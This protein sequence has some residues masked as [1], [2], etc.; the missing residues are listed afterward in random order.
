V[1]VVVVVRVF[2]VEDAVTPSKSVSGTVTM[3]P[4]RFPVGS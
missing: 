2:G 1:A 4:V 3:R